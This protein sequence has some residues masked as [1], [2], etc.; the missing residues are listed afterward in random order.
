MTGWGG[1]AAVGVV[2]LRGTSEPGPMPRPSL[3]ALRENSGEILRLGEVAPTGVIGP[4]PGSSGSAVVFQGM[5]RDGRSA[6]GAGI[7][8]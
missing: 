5:G 3:A 2:A 7:S 8:W 1:T 6:A 4:D